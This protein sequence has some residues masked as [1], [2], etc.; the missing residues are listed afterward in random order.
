MR[1]GAQVYTIR[2]FCK[3]LDDFSESMKRIA[4]IGYQYVQISGTC[5]YEPEWLKAELEKNGLACVITHI[6]A[7]R[8]LSDPAGVAHDHD[9]FGCKY[10]GLGWNACQLD[11]GDTPDAFYDKYIAAA[12]VLKERG[13]Y[14]MYHNHD[15]EFQ[16]YNGKPV[17]E[18]LAGMFAPDEMGWFY[19]GHLLDHR[20]RRR[21][22]MVDR[23]PERTC[24]LHPPEGFRLWKENGRDWR[25]QHQ[26]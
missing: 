19:A 9:I 15:Q 2:D 26:F 21:P 10:V 1:I 4:D 14:F 5:D 20:R 24:A 12:H 7:D 13:K 6:P 8:L 22:G 11:K 3:N 25:R 23:A 18:Q 16:K 17:L